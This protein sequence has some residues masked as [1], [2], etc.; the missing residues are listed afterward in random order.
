[1]E[2]IATVSLAGGQG[3]TTTC[4]FLSKMLAELGK[5][6]LVI[7]GDPQANLTFYLNHEVEANQPTLFE[8]LTGTVE[9]EDGIYPTEQENLF[10]IPA[11]NGLS[12]VGDFLT[13][14][15][16]GALILKL[17]LQAVK[18]IF[19]YVVIDVQP[20]RAPICLSAVGAAE[21]VLIPAEAATKG[22]NSL[23]DTLKFLEE[24]AA[25]MAFTGQVMG[26]IPFRD[27]WIG[28][29]QTLE[30]RENIAAMKE[31]AEEIEVLASIR[32]SEQFKRAMRQGKLL[33]ELG[34]TDLQYP[35]EQIIE[36]VTA[37]KT[38]SRARN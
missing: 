20:T 32:E 21:R 1:M 11:D 34:Q 38:L 6:V 2:V 33:S 27:R 8:V 28:R 5:K 29:T 9:T 37:K 10:L 13:S 7:D 25:V 4:F 26:A 35:F 18:D 30:S 12:K 19:D 24:Q 36:R 14:S 23:L 15:G 22:L 31:L 16:T 3:K 17:R